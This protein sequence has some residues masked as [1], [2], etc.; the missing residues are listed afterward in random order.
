MKV[1]SLGPP[2]P[3]R[4]RRLRFW[5]TFNYSEFFYVTTTAIFSR[6]PFAIFLTKAIT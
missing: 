1:I 2:S 4:E 5:H 6:T 3:G